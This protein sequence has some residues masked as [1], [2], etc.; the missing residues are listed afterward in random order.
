MR[1]LLSPNDLPKAPICVAFSGGLD[2]S[3]L[4]HL[5]AALPMARERGLR[6][7]H[8]H[9]GLQPAADGW[10]NHC[11][12]T[13][14][15]L[16]VE[17]RVS[18]VSVI[19]GGDGPE[20]A[21]RRA[22]RTAFASG[23][24]HGEVLALAHHQDDQAETFL[25]RAL[26]ASGIDGLAAMQPWQ[27]FASGFMWRPL[28]QAT[29][30]SLEDYATAHALR[31]IEDPS[32]SD[33]SMDRNFLRR[34]V[35]P[36]LRERWPHATAALAGSASLCAQAAGLLQQEDAAA[37][38]GVSGAE[39]G[40]LSRAKLLQ[41]NV[42][43]RA[44]V[45]RHWI[46]SLGL[47]PLPAT[48]V[49]RIESDL[50][51]A[52]DDASARFEW[53]NAAVVAWRDRLHAGPVR[54]PLPDGWQVEWDGR[55]PLDL[56]GGGTL[57][58]VTPPAPV[59]AASAAIGE[60]FARAGSTIAAE[61]APTRRRKSPWGTAA[62]GHGGR[63]PGFAEPLVVHARRGGERIALP[64]RAHSHA[65]KHVL[66]DTGVPPWVRAR[67]PLVSTRDGELLAAGDRLLSSS[68]SRRLAA[69]GARLEWD[70]G[71]GPA[72]VD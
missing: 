12:D 72:R 24:G 64:G 42:D 52:R 10:A 39:P 37:M 70:E 34:R 41:L 32:N 55:A 2:S 48:G 7:W 60:S 5:L 22:R 17:L 30:E 28:L 4:L 27:A 40:E 35:M 15:A 26:R 43:R 65:L 67:M 66:Q 54:P 21:A 16:D 36:V 25:L 13:C 8:V 51:R 23:L 18:R 71:S 44:R 61:A 53:N 46:D 59:G 29:R 56:P 38:A 3:V 69:H 19:A 50:L 20:A 47:P 49:A 57:A 9:H 14:R 6:A 62:S 63:M 31:W 68:F 58:L 11:A 33:V 1:A 45:L